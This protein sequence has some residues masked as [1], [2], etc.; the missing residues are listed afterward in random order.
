M[1]LAPTSVSR[2]RRPDAEHAASGCAGRGRR[3]PRATEGGVARRGRR[4]TPPRHLVRAAARVRR[5]RP[6]S[7][8]STARGRRVAIAG[9]GRQRTDPHGPIQP[10]HGNRE[11]ARGR[12]T[13]QCKTLEPRRRG[14]INPQRRG[15]RAG[16][17][18]SN[19]LPQRRRL[20][21]SRRSPADSRR[22]NDG[23]GAE[24]LIESPDFGRY[25][26]ELQARGCNPFD[27]LQVAD[28]ESATAT[29]LRGCSGL[30]G[31]TESAAGSRAR[32]SST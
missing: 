4:A 28:M 23:Q 10:S 19:E 24:A 11:D 29:S 5:A 30:T 13:E 31:H 6:S 18:T 27:V 7:R 16:P 8:A 21:A 9:D 22:T 1:K 3:C 17:S 14:P 2:P 15:F 32:S 12:G 20:A 26:Q 25:H